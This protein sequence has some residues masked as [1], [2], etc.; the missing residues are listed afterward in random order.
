MYQRNRSMLTIL[1]SKYMKYAHI[2]AELIGFVL[3]YIGEVIIFYAEAY[4]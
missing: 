1:V 3:T 4:I 2:E